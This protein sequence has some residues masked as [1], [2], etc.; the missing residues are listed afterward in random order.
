MI[1]L[2]Q[3]W[4]SRCQAIRS[5]RISP[6]AA[7]LRDDC[8]RAKRIKMTAFYCQA[9]RTFLSSGQVAGAGKGPK[10]IGSFRR[11]LLSS[12]GHAPNRI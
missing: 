5:T 7:V 12:R 2:I 4:W 11:N 6:A 8:G 10:T 9:C 3:A 1:R